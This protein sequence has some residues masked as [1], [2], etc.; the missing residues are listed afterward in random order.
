MK[1]TV[2][3]CNICK[4]ELDV[5]PYPA[6]ISVVSGVKLS[7]DMGS[8]EDDDSGDVCKDCQVAIARAVLDTV[9]DLQGD[10]E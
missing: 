7:Y 10:H 3:K 9:E 8:P 4:R 2:I 1:L 6:H 5:S